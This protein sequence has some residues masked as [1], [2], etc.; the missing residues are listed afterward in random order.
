MRRHVL[1]ATSKVTTGVDSLAATGSTADGSVYRR[2][3]RVIVTRSDT[4]AIDSSH[5]HAA[6][7]PTDMGFRP[8]SSNAAHPIAWTLHFCG[9]PPAYVLA[10]RAGS[11]PWRVQ[12]APACFGQDRA[13]GG[14]H[15]TVPVVAP[16]SRVDPSSE[17]SEEPHP[18]TSVEPISSQ[19]E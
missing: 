5:L 3:R 13:R 9:L 8:P 12:T 4:V 1:H 17:A 18:P 6:R 10:P 19:G 16:Q 14:Q 2:D 15:A 11:A 7:R